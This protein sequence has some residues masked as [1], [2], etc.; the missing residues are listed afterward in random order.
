[1]D[2]LLASE[3]IHKALATASDRGAWDSL[4]NKPKIL[5]ISHAC[6]TPINQSFYAD[7]AVV[8]DWSVELVVPTSWD[9]EYRTGVE[10]ERWPSFQGNIHSIP[11]WK[12]GNI[13]L[14]IYRSFFVALLRS[15]RP[16]FIY[17]HHEPYGLATAQIYLAN[18][19]SINCPIGFYAAQNIFKKYPFPFRFFERFVLK[20]SAFAFPVTGGALDVLRRKNYHGHA[21]VL[22]LPLDKSVYF[23]KD[24]WARAKRAEL[25]LDQQ[26][27]LVGYLGRLVEEKGL[28]TMLLALKALSPRPWRCLLVGSGPMKSELHDLASELDIAEHIVFIGF[29]PHEEVP[30][31]LSLF[32]VL[33]LASES[34]ANWKEQF[35]RV[36]T[37]ANACETAVIGTDS[38][39]IGNVLRSTGGGMVIPEGNV[40]QL[41]KALLRMVDNPNERRQLAQEGASAVALHYDQ[42]LLAGRFGSAIEAAIAERR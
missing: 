13:P 19:L 12:P 3:T 40:A 16:D 21:E 29:V 34:R 22:P 18:M 7:V 1:M 15:I 23:P 14:H 37:E 20:H 4:P 25:G 28:R 17:V 8:K 42:H 33:V 38:G 2:N 31:W 30:G 27:F 24:A 35:G 6:I 41:S 26:V 9:S 32:D 10:V 5:V 36:I 39:E 11:V